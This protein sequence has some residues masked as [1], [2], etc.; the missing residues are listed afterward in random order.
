MN[1]N[2]VWAWAI[3]NSICVICWTVLAIVFNKWW[4]AL[5]GAFF[6]SSLKTNVGKCRVCDKCGKHSPNAESYNEALD[7]AK[8]AGW[9]HYVEGNKDY[10]PE[11]QSKDNYSNMPD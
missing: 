5:F 11:C 6:I 7:K 1:K 10:C 2:A 3:K 8:E 9:V 4:I